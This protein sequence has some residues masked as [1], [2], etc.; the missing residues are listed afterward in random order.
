MRDLDNL[1]HRKCVSERELSY[2]FDLKSKRS[3]PDLDESELNF[4]SCLRHQSKCDNND[5]VDVISSTTTLTDTID[6]IQTSLIR[7]SYMTTRQ[8]TYVMRTQLVTMTNVYL[9]SKRVVRFPSTL[10]LHVILALG[11]FDDRSEV[12]SFFIYIDV[13]RRHCQYPERDCAAGI[14]IRYSVRQSKNQRSQKEF[15]V[16]KCSSRILIPITSASSDT[17]GRLLLII[18]F[19]DLVLD[20]SAFFSSHDRCLY[21]QVFLL[22][23]S[24]QAVDVSVIRKKTNSL[25]NLVVKKM[26]NWRRPCAETLRWWSVD[27]FSGVG[28]LDK[29]CLRPPCFSRHR[30]TSR[31]FDGLW[32]VLKKMFREGRRRR[33]T[34][35]EQK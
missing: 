24:T 11:V 10:V 18:L 9:E 30:S 28:L 13:R 4:F 19:D 27:Q 17:L 15:L 20:L 33:W 21:F 7:E 35:F 1:R 31:V 2:K 22:V 32:Y 29:V 12:F 34:K 23:T 14:D 25:L 5:M 3:N 8:M 16:I 6:V 26:T